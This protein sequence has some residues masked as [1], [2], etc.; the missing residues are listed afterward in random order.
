MK[1]SRSVL[2]WSFLA[3]CGLFLLTYAMG[4]QEGRYKLLGKP[5]P[6]FTLN[7][8]DGGKM[9]LAD[10]KGKDIVVLDFWAAWC[11]PCR[12]AMPKIVDLMDKYKSKGVV[13]YA[14]DLR[15]SA[16]AVK[17]FQQSTGLKFTVALDADGSIGD[18]Y[19]VDSI[20][21][22]VIIGKDGVVQAA[23]IGVTSDLVDNL[24]KELDTLVAGKSL[25]APEKPKT[26]PTP[27]AKK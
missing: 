10:H 25:V 8:V 12:M 4:A 9:N 2:L 11:P 16:D 13:F 26:E 22:D 19:S 5:A 3:V 15:E 6:Q 27:E 24:K 18:S 14:V 7:L 21:L 1:R 23:H 17:S 20:P